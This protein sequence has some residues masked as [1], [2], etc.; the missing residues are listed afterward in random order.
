MGKFSRDKGKRGE[1]EFASLCREHGFDAIRTAQHCGKN[2]GEADIK[3]ESLSEYHFE[4]KR[5]EKLSLYEAIGQAV[6]DCG[7]KVPIV[8]HKRNNCDWLVIMRAE[9]WLKGVQSR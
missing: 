3:S 6:R 1:R 4:V 8:A 2:G 9:D 7:D 5:T